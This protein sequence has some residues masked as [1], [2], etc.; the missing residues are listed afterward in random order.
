MTQFSKTNLPQDRIL[1]H[2]YFPKDHMLNILRPRV[3]SSTGCLLKAHSSCCAQDAVLGPGDIRRAGHW[4][5]DG[6]IW[7]SRVQHYTPVLWLASHPGHRRTGPLAGGSWSRP[8]AGWFFPCH[9][10]LNTGGERA[11]VLK[12]EVNSNLILEEDFPF[13]LKVRVES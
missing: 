5:A 10:S 3:R 2:I 9:K 13:I 7:R 6:C 1:L 8:P 11:K 12:T 4:C